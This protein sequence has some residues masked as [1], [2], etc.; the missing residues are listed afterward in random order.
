MIILENIPRTSTKCLPTLIQEK[1]T[2]L[3]K[4]ISIS[5]RSVSINHSM[6]ANDTIF[7]FQTDKTCN[8]NKIHIR[9]VFPTFKA[10]SQFQLVRNIVHP[11]TNPY[12]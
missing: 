1:H 7:F 5:R 6:F 9:L 8:N 4:G 3:L 12:T 11:N 2:N 10:S